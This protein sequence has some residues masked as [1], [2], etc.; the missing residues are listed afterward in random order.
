M[1]D[2]KPLGGLYESLE[3]FPSAW[4]T[5][6]SS[7]KVGRDFTCSTATIR[8]IKTIADDTITKLKGSGIQSS[9]FESYDLIKPD[10]MTDSES[11]KS[12]SATNL[13]LGL[14]QTTLGN[15]PIY[16]FVNLCDAI[17]DSVAVLKVI[18]TARERPTLDPPDQPKL[19]ALLEAVS[20]DATIILTAMGDAGA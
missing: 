1:T 20:A 14:P 15:E 5:M 6:G 18:V 13:E 8:T 11:E 2:P 19:L 3:G 17:A 12:W 7:R 10:R 16:E 9:K 4:K